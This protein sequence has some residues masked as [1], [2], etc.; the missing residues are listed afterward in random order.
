MIQQTSDITYRVYDWDRKDHQGNQRELHTEQALDALDFSAD[1]SFRLSYGRTENQINNI[2]SSPYF[3]TGFLEVTAAL[4][5]DY[6]Q[7]D[8]FKILMC[9]Q[10][11]GKIITNDFSLDI[12]LGETI[13]IPAKIKNVT[14]TS[15]I[16][17]VQF[18]E[19]YIK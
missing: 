8:S 9:V 13:L 16:G 17:E 14:I 2:I 7:Q 5:R 6:S 12:V 18:L 11:K 4:E 10:G 19:V 3:T 15:D 1:K